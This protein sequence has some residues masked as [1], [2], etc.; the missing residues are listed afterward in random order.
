MTILTALRELAGKAT[1]FPN[2]QRPSD[3]AGYYECP[4]CDGEGSV[5]AETV[6]EMRATNWA[7][8]V[9]F[10][11]IGHEHQD[12]EEFYRLC[13][14]MVPA[15]LDVAEAAHRMNVFHSGEINASHRYDEM[16]EW[17]Y[18]QTGLMAPG[19]DQ[20]D[21][22]DDME[23]RRDVWA[24]WRKDLP[25]MLV[26]QLTKALANLNDKESAK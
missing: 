13:L 1:P 14:K 23:A 3:E 17:F 26:A 4:L 11:G 18:R 25:D 22:R 9:Q 16:A 7:G 19:K 21:G 15:L 20:R 8:G 12:C 6:T 10:Y 5:P 24:A 2:E